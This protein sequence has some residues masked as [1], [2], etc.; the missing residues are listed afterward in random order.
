MLLPRRGSR[1]SRYIQ[2]CALLLGIL[3]VLALLPN[4]FQALQ[5]AE[6][7]FRADNPTRLPLPQ[8]P[9]PH[10]GD[11]ITFA[12]Q[13]FRAAVFHSQTGR[14]LQRRSEVLVEPQGPQTHEPAV[15]VPEPAAAVANAVRQ[16]RALARS[17]VDLKNDYERLARYHDKLQ[18]K[19]ES[20]SLSNEQLLKRHEQLQKSVGELLRYNKELQSN[21]TELKNTRERLQKNYERLDRVYSELRRRASD[22]VPVAVAPPSLRTFNQ[23]VPTQAA[24]NG[25]GHTNN[26]VMR[27]GPAKFPPDFTN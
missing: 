1:W 16:R 6:S 19:F 20:L 14:E 7:V 25:E 21:V 8:G 15:V 24:T 17:V 27:T 12:L 23:S 3:T 2:A 11:E 10:I 22:S 4:H 9:L 13:D 5:A 26:E 18:R